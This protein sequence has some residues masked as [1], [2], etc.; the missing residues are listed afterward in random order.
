MIG[1]MYERWRPA[2]SKASMVAIVMAASLILAGAAL[3]VAVYS[4]RQAPVCGVS[5]A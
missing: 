5:H 4:V 3:G 2:V 1:L